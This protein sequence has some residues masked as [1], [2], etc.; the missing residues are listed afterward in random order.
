MKSFPKHFR[1]H[2]IETSWGLPNLHFLQKFAFFKIN[3]A[4]NTAIKQLNFINMPKYTYRNVANS[5]SC[6]PSIWQHIKALPSHKSVL[7]QWTLSH[8][9]GPT[10]K[11]Y[12]FKQPLNHRE[13]EF[14]LQDL[15]L[16]ELKLEPHF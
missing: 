7:V 13:F 11:N 9:G 10:Q 1:L 3:K 6:F 5:L 12:A 4:A 15:M 14:S 2:T 8:L 16:F